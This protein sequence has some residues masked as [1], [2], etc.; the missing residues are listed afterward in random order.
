MT[1]IE[2]NPHLDVAGALV[3]ITLG[4]L[5]L[6]SNFNLLPANFWPMIWRFW[7]LLL[8]F[9]GLQN[10]FGNHPLGNVIT[11][12]LGAAVIYLIL[13]WALHW[14]LPPVL[15]DLETKLPRSENLRPR[16]L[17]PMPFYQR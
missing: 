17:R 12:I 8:I 6:L 4:T 7:P 1:M 5:L 9:F 14:P 2:K 15:R 16:P 13:A 11:F 10:I 3:L